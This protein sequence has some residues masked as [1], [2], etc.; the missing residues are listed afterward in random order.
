MTLREKIVN[1]ETG[2][3][4]FRDFTAEE[5]K[6]Y[7]AEKLLREKKLANLEAEQAA[8]ETA[9]QAVLSKLGLTAEEA[10]ALLA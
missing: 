4:T 1:A 5:I 2:E 7:E 8:K 9:R 3:E 10:A 6:R